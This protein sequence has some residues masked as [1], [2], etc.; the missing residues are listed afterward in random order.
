VLP[1]LR[2]NRPISLNKTL[3]IDGIGISALTING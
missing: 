2:K 3:T 1:C